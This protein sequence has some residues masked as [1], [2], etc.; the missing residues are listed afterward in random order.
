MS[1]IVSENKV[2]RAQTDKVIPK[3]NEVGDEP[4]KRIIYLASELPGVPEVINLTQL[5][6][7]PPCITIFEDEADWEADASFYQDDCKTQRL[8]PISGSSLD[9]K[10]P[11]EKDKTTFQERLLDKKNTILSRAIYLI[12]LFF[13]KKEYSNFFLDFRNLNSFPELVPED[14]FQAKVLN[15]T[16]FNRNKLM[17]KHGINEAELNFIAFARFRYPFITRGEEEW[18][19]IEKNAFTFIKRGWL[20]EDIR[21]NFKINV[22]N[23]YEFRDSIVFPKQLKEIV[24][25][26]VLRSKTL[27]KI[28]RNIERSAKTQVYNYNISQISKLPF[29]QFGNTNSTTHPPVGK[30]DLKVSKSIKNKP[31]CFTKDLKHKPLSERLKK[32]ETFSKEEPSKI[33]NTKKELK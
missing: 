21:G 28:L 30:N 23:V 7:S 4:E 32:T 33:C 20:S 8:R 13:L 16:K 6:T 17:K 11:K 12:N 31:I 26:K 2:V 24:F 19:E 9:S 3:R 29:T 15:L 10:I 14:V 27:H 25:K 5:D 18:V 22:G 1:E